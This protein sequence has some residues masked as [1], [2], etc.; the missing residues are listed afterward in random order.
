MVR[1]ARQH[2]LFRPASE[3]TM[4]Y[5][6][7]GDGCCWLLPRFNRKRP[8]RATA[9]MSSTVYP[10]QLLCSAPIIPSERRVRTVAAHKNDLRKSKASKNFAKKIN[11]IVYRRLLLLT[12]SILYTRAHIKFKTQTIKMRNGKIHKHKYK[13]TRYLFN[14]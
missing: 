1:I 3:H 10:M 7:N 6:S 2:R 14:L 11:F 5:S 13:H 12:L 4:Q 9:M 8:A